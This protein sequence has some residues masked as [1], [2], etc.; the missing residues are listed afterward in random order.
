MHNFLSK[1]NVEDLLEKLS[2]DE[3]KENIRKK[4]I[5]ELKHKLNKKKLIH[6]DQNINKIID[7]WLLNRP[8]SESDW[9][10]F[11]NIFKHKIPSHKLL[12][13]KKAIAHAYREFKH[14]FITPLKYIDSIAHRR[15]RGSA[16]PAEK[17]EPCLKDKCKCEQYSIVPGDSNPYVVNNKDEVYSILSPEHET[18]NCG[19]QTIEGDFQIIPNW[20]KERESILISGPSGAGK[21]FQAIEYLEKYHK[22]YPK[23]DIV[24][25]ANKPFEKFKIRYSHPTLDEEKIDKMRV[26][27]FKDSILVFDDVE[28]LT[29]NK[30]IQDKM[31]KFLEECL[32]VGRSLKVS[33]IIISHVLLNYRF[34]RNM[35][36]ECNKVMMFPNSGIKYQYQNFLKTYVGLS[37]E[38]IEN[39]FETNSRWLVVDKTTP[40][41]YI[42][43]NKFEIIK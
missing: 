10:A 40:I 13:F 6:W 36:M 38:Q 26:N 14:E 9:V 30:N 32:N 25:F 33:I 22:I 23:N 16:K 37:K 29:T 20:K 24:L 15:I 42:T 27:D 11:L 28:N 12:N 2:V 35:I 31:I 39:I 7:Q 1:D 18:K 43:K 34:S 19:V 3:T 17:K 5:E 21:T 8:H 4:A 41:C